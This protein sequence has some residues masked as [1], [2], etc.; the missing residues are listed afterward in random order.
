MSFSL[1]LII[2]AML[3]FSFRLLCIRNA[4]SKH[5]V[6]WS[7]KA[8]S[9]FVAP[10]QKRRS[11]VYS[12]WDILQTTKWHKINTL[13]C[14]HFFFVYPCSARLHDLGLRLLIVLDLKYFVAP[15]QRTFFFLKMSDMPGMICTSQR[16]ACVIFDEKVKEKSFCWD[17]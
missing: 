2:C 10:A 13:E 16:L 8:E 14:V 1:K 3:L 6:S 17:K 11:S 7:N 5:A 4:F 12:I 9:V 15:R